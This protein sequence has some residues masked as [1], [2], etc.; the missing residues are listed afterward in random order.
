[1]DTREDHMTSWPMQDM[2]LADTC[3][4]SLGAALTAVARAWHALSQERL[5][6]LQAHISGDVQAISGHACCWLAAASMHG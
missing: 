3:M 2:G 6:R 4:C 1:M 5:L